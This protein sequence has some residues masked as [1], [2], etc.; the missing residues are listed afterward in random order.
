MV[1]D[2]TQLHHPGSL[3]AVAR[4]P[5]LWIIL[6]SLL[7]SGLSPA[8]GAALEDLVDLELKPAWQGFVR[9]GE[10]SALALRFIA[11][12]GGRAELRLAGS[13]VTIRS[14]FEFEPGLPV[15]LSLPLPFTTGKTPRLSILANGERFERKVEVQAL[16]PATK[17]V[18]VVGEGESLPWPVPGAS[19][20]D[21]VTVHLRAAELPGRAQAYRQLDALV[22]SEAAVDS[23]DKRREQAIA[24][25]LAA[26]GVL[27]LP[28]HL[29]GVGSGAHAAA[30]C[31]GRNV[32]PLDA[33]SNALKASPRRGRLPG[34]AVL[35]ELPVPSQSG[36]H[37][38]LVV[39][40]AGYLGLLVLLARSTPSS[41][42]LLIPP[43]AAGCA[44][45]GWSMSRPLISLTAWA[46]MNSG[47]TLAPYA[48]SLQVTG[49][50]RGQVTVPLA[51]DSGVPEAEAG[52]GVVFHAEET[53]ASL[54]LP[55]R[56]M[57]RHKLLF[58]GIMPA[59]RFEVQGGEDGV[60][61][62]NLGDAPLPAGLVAW[63]GQRYS[64]PELAAGQSWQ[65]PERGEP[66][67]N[68][69]GESELRRRALDGGTWVLAPVAPPA[70]L[71][72]TA[73][74]GTSGWIL[75]KGDEHDR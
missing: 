14:S 33:G 62:Q 51:A 42:L 71:A 11:P 46:E 75:V 38:S 13:G 37:W 24:G 45:L 68:R 60:R 27:Y 43:A 19:D 30:G 15:E 47:D 63:Q 44:I 50:S 66:W 52:D 3:I 31:G 65:Q 41:L 74:T 7:V 9:P 59:P 5:R 20:R 2:R 48:A 49:T 40:L 17:L 23:L 55:G 57:S 25:Y 12:R 21:T 18:A 58:R 8:A 10:T 39:F 29:T 54:T 64:F 61:I 34:A 70:A 32:I 67:G 35:R 6:F 1:G 69:P 36:V 53:G 28:A 4:S 73:G 16:S 22:L 26:C 56:L 72:E